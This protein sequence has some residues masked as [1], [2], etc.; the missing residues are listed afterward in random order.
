MN[1]FEF[2][3]S[4]VQAKDLGSA[5]QR[6]GHVGSKTTD[7]LKPVIVKTFKTRSISLSNPFDKIDKPGR[8]INPNGRFVF[9]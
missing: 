1:F 3:D 8:S 4:S 5:G 9:K 6:S 7:D 2:L